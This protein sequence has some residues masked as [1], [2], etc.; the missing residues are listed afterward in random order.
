MNPPSDEFLMT[1]G[2]TIDLIKDYDKFIET[3]EKM[4]MTGLIAKGPNA[5]KPF[6]NSFQAYLLQRGKYL[7]QEMDRLEKKLQKMDIQLAKYDKQHIDNIA[8]GVAN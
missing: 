5:G 6:D 1:Y 8:L 3:N 7:Q 4:L 2:Q